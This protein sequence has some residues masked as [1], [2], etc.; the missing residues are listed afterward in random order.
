MEVVNGATRGLSPLQELQVPREANCEGEEMNDTI[1]QTYRGV[2]IVYIE[3]ADR[4]NFIAN[5]RERNAESLA[6]AKESIDRSLDYER[7]ERPWKPFAAYHKDYGRGFDPVTVTSEADRDY[8]SDKYFWIS[9]AGKNGR[10]E[11]SKESEFELYA[12]S[13]E[14][15]QKIAR[16]R[17]LDAEIKRLSSEQRQLVETM[18]K[19]TAPVH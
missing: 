2:E 5:G 16:Y 18:T 6:K 11:R 9:K 8:G 4:W 1:T 15:E 17:E 13:V 7:K 3:S 14:N 19:V 10:K 12:A